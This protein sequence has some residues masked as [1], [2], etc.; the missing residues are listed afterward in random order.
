M[1]ARLEAD[2]KENSRKW[3]PTPGQQTF[4]DENRKWFDYAKTLDYQAFLKCFTT[5][6]QLIDDTDD[7]TEKKSVAGSNLS[8]LNKH[9][10]RIEEALTGNTMISS[11]RRVSRIFPNLSRK[12]N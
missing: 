4:I 5:K 7:D 12:R 8:P 10:F 6:E 2:D 1:L 9:L 3:S 11:R